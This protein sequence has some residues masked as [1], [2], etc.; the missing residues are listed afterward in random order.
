MLVRFLKNHKFE[1]SGIGLIITGILLFVSTVGVFFP[2]SELATDSE[3]ISN[4]L[5]FLGDWDYWVFIITIIVFVACLWIFIDFILKLRKFSNYIETGS[6][7]T[8]IKNKEEIEFLA[9]ELGEK[10]IEQYE[11]RK[12]ELRIRD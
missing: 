9:W 8:F 1:L 7:S 10:F 11:E 6:K 12:K 3:Y 5:D 2:K 4:I